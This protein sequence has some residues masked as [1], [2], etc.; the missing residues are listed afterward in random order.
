ML[1][2]P[3]ALERAMKIQEVILRGL[4]GEITWLQAADILGRSPR[5]MRRLRVKFERYGFE[6]LYDRRR[7]TPSPKRAPVAE[8]QRVLALYRAQYQGF[9]VRHFHQ[10]ARRHH[11]AHE[12]TSRTG[13]CVGG[14]TKDRRKP[15]PFRDQIGEPGQNASRRVRISPG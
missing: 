3:E 2:P 11:Q 1:Y 6:D 4:S 5:S 12:H 9:N 15:P 13:A 8:V 10:I 14:P 7:R